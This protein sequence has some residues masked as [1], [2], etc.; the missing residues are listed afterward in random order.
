MADPITVAIASAVAGKAAESF[1]GQTGRA[2]AAIIKRIRDKFQ[3]RPAALATLDAVEEGH[4]SAAELT[5]LLDQAS[6]EDPEFGRQISALWNQAAVTA[7]D[8]GVVNF[9]H[10]NA[11]KVVQMRDI[12]GDLTIS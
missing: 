10:G 3:G 5:A 8:G 9:F 11:D 2:L 7:T 12:H 1:S 6:A 4:G